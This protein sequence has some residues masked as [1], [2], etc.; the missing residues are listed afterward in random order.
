MGPSGA[1]K[2]KPRR[3]NDE[4]LHAREVNATRKAQ[5]KTTKSV[6]SVSRSKARAQAY[7]ARVPQPVP[8][9]NIG[10]PAQFPPQPPAAPAPVRSPII[11]TEGP[12][13][14]QTEGES[15]PS[16]LPESTQQP[17]GEVLP[18]ASSHSTRAS[19]RFV[20][21]PPPPP[22]AQRPN[23]EEQGEIPPQ[24]GTSNSA[25]SPV[26]VE[27]EE[28]APGATP[29]A[30][31]APPSH[32]PI[33]VESEEE[34]S[35]EAPSTR[36]EVLP[37]SAKE[38]LQAIFAKAKSNPLTPHDRVELADSEPKTPW[39]RRVKLR[40]E[41]PRAEPEPPGDLLRP[42]SKAEGELPILHG[43][44]VGAGVP[45]NV[46]LSLPKTLGFEWDQEGPSGPLLE[47]LGKGQDR[48]A[49]MSQDMVLK[50]SQHSQKQEHTLAKLLPGIAAPVFW[51]E[52]VMV[53]LHDDKGGMQNIAMTCLCQQPVIKAVDVMEARGAVFS[54]RFLCHVGCIL[55]WL[56]TQKLHL[57]DLGESNMGM[58]QAS[59]AEAWT[60][61]CV[62]STC[63][64]GSVSRNLTPSGTGTTH[65]RKRCAQSTRSGSRLRA[66]RLP[67]MLIKFSDSL[68]LS[69]RVTQT[70]WFRQGSWL[71]E[72]CRPDR[73]PFEGEFLP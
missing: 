24:S 71:M 8:G 67:G 54:F 41:P 38:R 44:R 63:C 21:R 68:L 69:A 25:S 33:P 72:S 36:G 59:T 5:G 11:L 3:S 51:V 10:A 57:L 65:W 45:R 12:G 23:E 48:V 37:R 35:A 9:D 39:A 17:R 6:A 4:K 32:S 61:P 22:K 42:R 56:W 20:L 70:A 60:Q 16:S 27:S 26:P 1:G 53:V 29:K 58:E 62:S 31:G 55:T 64:R 15:L 46:L 2:G 7:H 66:Q 34:A 19:A 13:A 49:Y 28:E 73:Y 50:L 40:S 18:Q 30:K 52:N 47:F 14:S 43:R